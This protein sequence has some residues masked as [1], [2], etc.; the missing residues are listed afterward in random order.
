MIVEE[1]ISLSPLTTLGVG[2][3]ARFFT[4]VQSVEEVKE[5]LAFARAHTLP[6]FVLGGGSNL[7]VPDNGVHGVVLKMTMCDIHFENDGDDILLTA[8]VGAH[9][10]DVVDAVG[11]RGIFGIENLAGIPGTAGG[12]VV[13]NIGAYG[14]ELANVFEY[15]D[16]IN[17]A[18]GENI[19][20][21]LSEA[22]FAYRS[23]FFKRH[24]ELV[25]TR[26][27]LRLKNNSVANIS[28]PDLVSAR[29]SGVPLATPVEIARAVRNIRSEKFPACRQAGQDITEEGTAGSFFKNPI[30]PRELADSLAKRFVGL[31]IFTEDDGMMKISLAW[32]LD[33]AISLK[34]FSVGGARLYEKQPLVIVTRAGATAREVDLLAREVS[35]KVFDKTGIR[36][37]REVETFGE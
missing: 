1:H 31:P 28:Y 26:V 29:D 2:G 12:A 7:L 19:R 27:A 14:A 16:V 37:E 23:S 25:I 13:Q 4:E 34:G 32:F 22:E 36:I 8:G 21:T 35:E 3:E 9:W 6:V 33:K 24:R 11:T 17:S 30:I 5:A 18:T 20:V 10:D 15:A